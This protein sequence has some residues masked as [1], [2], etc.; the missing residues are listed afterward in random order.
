[1]S[2]SELRFPFVTIQPGDIPRPYIPVTIA[3]PDSGKGMNVYALIDTG[4][5]ECALPASFAQVLGHNLEAGTMKQISTGNGVTAAYGHT[6]V[7]DVK[8]FSTGPIAVDYMPNLAVP[9]LGTKS[10]LARFVL[11]VDYPAMELCLGQSVS[12]TPSA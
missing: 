4:A 8:G 6:T 3:N 11:T 9:L 2:M 12:D 7:V 10:F 1:M 5:D